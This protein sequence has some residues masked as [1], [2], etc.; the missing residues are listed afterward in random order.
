[1]YGFSSGNLT[2]KSKAIIN[3]EFV[4]YLP[5]KFIGFQFAPVLF[6]SV[7]GLA[8]NFGNMFSNTFYQSFALGVLIRNEYLVSSTFEFSIGF[9]PYMPGRADNS[10]IANPINNYNAQARDY[11][12][13]KPDLVHYK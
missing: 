2:G 3:L 11:F 9:Y 1:M 7:A 10:F 12:I 5:Y 8:N 4:L 6:Y 13:T